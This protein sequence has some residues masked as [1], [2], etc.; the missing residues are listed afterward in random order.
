M[1]DADVPAARGVEGWTEAS[2][3]GATAAGAMTAGLEALAARLL[4]SASVWQRDAWSESLHTTQFF[5]ASRLTLD[6]TMIQSELNGIDGRASSQVVHSRLETFLPSVEVHRGQLTHRRVGQV[7]VERLGLVD[8]GTSVGGEV[9]DGLLADLPDGLVDRFELGRDAGNVL[10]GTAVGD[11]V[12][13]SRS[14]DQ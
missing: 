3:G 6:E 1:A 4:A 11:A 13:R 12:R 14:Y 8:E 5:V 9:D 7:D 2:G 10:N